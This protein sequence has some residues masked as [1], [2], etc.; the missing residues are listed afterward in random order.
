MRHY[1][2]CSEWKLWPKIAKIANFATFDTKKY[3]F[4]QFDYNKIQFFQ[5]FTMIM[6]FSF[7]DRVTQQS[8]G[9]ESVISGYSSPEITIFWRFSWIFGHFRCNLFF[10]PPNLQLNDYTLE[11][12][13]LQ[14]L[15]NFVKSSSSQSILRETKS[16]MC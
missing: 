2:K 16:D 12:F 11:K 8:E 9:Q 7:W 13:G 4:R 6:N 10:I 3:I 14:K 1:S 15:K 5:N